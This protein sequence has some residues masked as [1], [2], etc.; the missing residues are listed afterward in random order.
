[1]ETILTTLTKVREIY[2]FDY[3]MNDTQFNQYMLRVQRSTLKSALGADLYNDI[4]AD[5]PSI[6]Y[7]S[8]LDPYIYNYMSAAFACLFI[9]EGNLF[10]TNR[11]NYQFEQD[12]TQNATK[13]QLM[14]TE[15]N[16]K[17]EQT[18]YHNE[19]IEYLDDNKSTYPLWQNES[20]ES[21]GFIMGIV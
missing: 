13:W 3:N 20:E 11:G 2:D 16:Y 8:L 18:L 10:H 14:E 12:T 5:S 17:G 15:G 1:M 7:T 21:D 9:V 4:T 6:S 19:M